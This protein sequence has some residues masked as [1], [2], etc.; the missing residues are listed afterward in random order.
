MPRVMLL[1]RLTRWAIREF[2]NLLIPTATRQLRHVVIA[3]LLFAI[4]PF[5]Q[6]A[7][8]PYEIEGSSGDSYQITRSEQAAGIIP[9]NL[10]Y[11][12]GDV[13]RYGAIGDGINDD[14]V[15]LQS[16]LD[17]KSALTYIPKPPVKYMTDQLLLPSD[18]NL[19]IESGTVIEAKPGYGKHDVVLLARNVSNIK[20]SGYGATLQMPKSEYSGMYR[21]GLSI[22]GSNN[23]EVEGLASN[24]TGGDGFYV[25]EAKRPYSQDIVLRDISADN[26]RR[27]GLSIVSARNIRVINARLTNT[28]CDDRQSVH[29]K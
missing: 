20:I 27:Q 26:N 23:I 7:G 29:R 22:R 11:R 24:N 15:A 19:F 10:I 6:S 16:A 4:L 28:E 2:E 14:S 9:Q 13:R 21:H 5:T 8:S 25:G 12:P 17:S 18:T 3:I 1:R